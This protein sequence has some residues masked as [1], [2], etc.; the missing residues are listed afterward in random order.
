LVRFANVNGKVYPYRYGDGRARANAEFLNGLIRYNGFYLNTDGHLSSDKKLQDDNKYHNFSYSLI[1]EASYT[2]YEK[3]VLDTLHPAG[4]KLVPVHVVKQ[5]LTVN[6]LSNTNTHIFIQD[7]NTLIGCCNIGYDSTEITGVSENFD[8]LANVNDLIVINSGNV[9]RTFTKVITSIANNNSLNIESSC[10]IVGE[11]RGKTN[12]NLATL[13]ISGNTNAINRFIDTGD[14]IKINVGNTVLIKTIN[15]ISGNVITLNSNTGIN[16]TN[17]N[18]VYLVLP[19]FT[20]V[21]YQIVQT[22]R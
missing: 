20:D 21:L 22:D 14:R 15:S 6:Q 19:Q 17:S 16:T 12:A 8:T 11:G 10:I 18:L 4:A 5:E 1:S 3:T 2:D 13:T 7:S 9:Y